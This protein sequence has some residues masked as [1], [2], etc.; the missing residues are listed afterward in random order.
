M[1]DCSPTIGQ[2][3]A[4]YYRDELAPADAAGNYSK[5]PSK[6][7]RFKEFLQQTSLWPHVEVHSQFAPVTRDDLLLA[8]EP[9]Y[10]DAFLNGVQPRCE[11]NGLV[12]SPQFRDSVLWTNG[13]LVAAM[14]AAIRNPA[15]VTMAPVSGFHHAT[16]SSGGGF[17]T[18]SG[19]V[20]AALKLYRSGGLRGVWFDLDGHFGNSSE[21]SREFAPVLNQAVAPEFNINPIGA[22]ARYLADLDTQIARVR[23]R[24]LAGALDYVVFAHGADSHEW[25]QLGHQCTTAQWLSAATRIY[26]MLRDVRDVRPVPVTLALFGGYRDD[27]PESVLGLHAMDL[28]ECLRL[29]CGRPVVYEAEVRE[30]WRGPR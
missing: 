21:D 29:L 13:S 17:C 12:W 30:P 24:L 5:S 16:P 18:F 9:R 8:H 7:A 27:H 4:L 10:V 26:S 3:V 6:P 22:G 11:S 25:D 23:A 19:Q 15:Q 2:P 28:A 20:I 1:H 14:E